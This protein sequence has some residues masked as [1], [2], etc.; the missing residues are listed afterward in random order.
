MRL[1]ATAPLE[2]MQQDFL[3][4]MSLAT[5]EARKRMLWL[6]NKALD[7][8]RTLLMDGFLSAPLSD[9]I[10]ARFPFLG[11]TAR[12]VEKYMSC[13]KVLEDEEGCNLC[14]DSSRLKLWGIP[15]NFSEML[16]WGTPECPTIPHIRVALDRLNRELETIYGQAK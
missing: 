8:M 2:Q 12:F 10:K 5:Q 11:N 14:F 7:H 4:A 16:E 13:W 3:A 15:E 1:L 9:E 6:A